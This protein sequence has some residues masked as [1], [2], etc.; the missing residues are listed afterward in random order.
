MFFGNALRIFV[1]DEA[2]MY[3]GT[4]AAEMA[5]LL[6]RVLIQCGVR[7]ETI[8]QIATSATLGGNV[9]EFAARLFSK[10]L[11]SVQWVQGESVR[12]ALPEPIA[13]VRACRPDDVQ[14]DALEAAVLVG[15]DGLVVDTALAD[16]ARSCV[17]FLVGPEVIVET[18]QDG[19]P[20][21]VLRHTLS[22]APIIA[23]LENALWNSRK[24]GILRLRDLAAALWNS[25]D[26]SAISA[27]A[28]LLQLGSRARCS[29]SEL[30]LVPHK[31]HLMA[32]A[33]VTVS[34]CLNAR[35][36]AQMSRLPLGGRLVAEGV[37][38]CP[39]CGCAML[40]LCRCDRCG[41]DLVAGIHRTDNTLNGRPE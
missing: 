33:P 19:M 18:L 15:Q 7:G 37:D 6:R 13:P 38:L 12:P 8:L 5:L 9:Q 36:S 29:I 2:H 25:S 3:T 39:D 35:C 22:R 23:Q 16:V 28:R 26:E 27:T 21:S 31:L 10:D 41:Q 30:P 11:T 32:R 24:E 4:L 34:A 14:M 40:T 17:R 20:A 1:A